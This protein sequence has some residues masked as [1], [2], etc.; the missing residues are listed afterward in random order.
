MEGK[1]LRAVLPGVHDIYITSSE[2]L[3]SLTLL[4]CILLCPNLERLNISNLTMLN[5]I[6]LAKQLNDQLNDDQWL[7]SI[8]VQIQRLI[9]IKRS[10]DFYLIT[11]KQLSMEFA[12][13]FSRARIW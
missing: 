3:H 11:R 8:L 13:V 7:K 9:L 5:R 2:K 4:V 12:K 1:L 10:D 6:E